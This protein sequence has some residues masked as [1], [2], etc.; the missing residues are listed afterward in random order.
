MTPRRRLLVAALM[1]AAP[2][3]T[4]FAPAPANASPT[5]MSMMMDDNLLLYRSDHVAARALT[6]MKTMGVDAVR[7][8][9]LWRTV[10]EFAYP[11]LRDIE[12]LEGKARSR[13]VRQRHRF[14]ADDPRTY[15]RG[16][17]DRYDN[18]VKA[19]TQR[20]LR[21]HFNVTGPGPIWAQRTPPRRLRRLLASYKP[22]VGAFKQFVKAV[23]RRFDGTYRDENGVRDVLPR[24]SMWSLWN[25]P[26]QAGWL[27]PQWERRNGRWVPAA[28]ALFRRLVQQG[29]EGLVATG[30][31][32][33]NDL[34]LLGETAPLGSGRRSERAPMYPKRFLRELMCVRS[35][36]RAYTGRSARL[37]NCDDFRKKGPLRATGYAHHPYTKNLAPTQRHRA[38]DALTMAN[39]SELG[40]LLDE[41]AA[42]TG[43][44]PAGLPLY[45]TEFGY[46]TSPP[47]RFSGVPLLAQATF[48]TLGEYLAWADPRIAAQSQFLLADVA[49][50]KKH[51]RG[52][53]SYWSTY[54]SGLI[55]QQGRAKL[56]AYAY[57]MPFMATRTTSAAAGVAATVNVWGQLRFLPNGQPGDVAIQWRP[58]DG[59]APW[60]TVGERV[61]TDALGYY[62]ASRTAPGAGPGEWRALWSAGDGGEELA[63]LVVPD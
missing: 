28:P 25:E 30:H 51:R 19:A 27:S 31:R 21:V 12:K 49:P 47:D 18:L 7:V 33:D 29:Y 9:V 40:G 56:A 41:L 1:L 44:L 3:S 22:K 5:Q 62:T 39:I 55:T 11:R 46:E 42:T 34:I 43:H 63:S 26:N 2:A 32:A 54:Q 6:Q 13:A 24:V 57:T 36:G 23:G 4:A 15:P 16:N 20:G 59:S 10:A 60:A 53:K 35:D 8:T 45:M 52:T 48:N 61:A 50:L 58:R 38:A 14:D 37:R 17:W